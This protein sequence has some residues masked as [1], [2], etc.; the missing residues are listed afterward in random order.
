ML[1]GIAAAIGCCTMHNTKNLTKLSAVDLSQVVGGQLAPI[2]GSVAGGIAGSAGG[3]I[4]KRLGD[5][6]G[7]PK[8]DDPKT[9][10]PSSST[11]NDCIKIVK[12]KTADDINK[13][14]GNP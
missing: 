6:L 9:K 10:E 11:R 4:S 14:C 3:E 7:G 1:R 2:V 5:L 13:I 12:D 8:K